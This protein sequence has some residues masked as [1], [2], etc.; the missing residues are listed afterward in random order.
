ME[1]GISFPFARDNNEKENIFSHRKAPPHTILITD[2]YRE[3]EISQ[4]VGCICRSER[5]T[6]I[7]RSHHPPLRLPSWT[8]PVRTHT[9]SYL[10]Q[11][12]Q[13]IRPRLSGPT[14]ATSRQKNY[15][16]LSFPKSPLLFLL[17]THLPQSPPPSPSLLSLQSPARDTTRVKLPAAAA[18]DRRSSV[19]VLPSTL[20]AE[21]W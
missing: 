16:S 9:S 2:R 17:S 21:P 10:P 3:A 1:L 20:R 12:S 4:T 13:P 11:V 8:P 6:P 18:G 15:P 14:P 19:P 7:S 5:A